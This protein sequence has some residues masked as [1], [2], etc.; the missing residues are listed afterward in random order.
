MQSFPDTTKDEDSFDMDHKL[1][2]DPQKALLP[3]IWV[4]YYDRIMENTKRI[5]R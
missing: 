2:E 1:L 4:D 5:N 3:P